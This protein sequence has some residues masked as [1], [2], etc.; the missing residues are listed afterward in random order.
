M[1]V[2]ESLREFWGSLPESGIVVLLP[3]TVSEI[4][5]SEFAL[6]GTVKVQVADGLLKPAS[7]FREELLQ[8]VRAAAEAG[9]ELGECFDAYLEPS[10]FDE[11]NK[12]HCPFCQARVCAIKRTVICRLP[13]VMI[14]QLNRFR[15][16]PWMPKDDTPVRVELEID[17]RKFVEEPQE[18][19]HF[20]FKLFGVVNHLGNSLGVQGGHYKAFARHHIEG[21]WHEYNDQ[22]R[23]LTE[24]DDTDLH[25][26]RDAYILFYERVGADG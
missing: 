2:Q 13:P 1:V 12:W 15:N 22:F 8:P 6:D 25:R 19:E 4:E 21:T 14:L 23:C 3:E 18:G 16:G 9:M 17:M 11:R 10:Q 26:M 24:P 5:G 20:V 7:G